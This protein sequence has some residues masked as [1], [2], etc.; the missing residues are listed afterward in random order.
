MVYKDD[1]YDVFFQDIIGR[2]YGVRASGMIK[3]IQ[4]YFREIKKSMGSQKVTEVQ[5]GGST[6]D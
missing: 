3:N 6:Y 1:D 2:E 5:Q 4:G